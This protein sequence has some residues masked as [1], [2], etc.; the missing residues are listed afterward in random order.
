MSVQCGV[1]EEYDGPHLESK[2]KEESLVEEEFKE[3]RGDVNALRTTIG[4][5]LAEGAELEDLQ[6][7]QLCQMGFFFFE[8]ISTWLY[9]G[10]SPSSDRDD[11]DSK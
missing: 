9:R 11:D 7:R 5:N 3:E 10:E 2:N 6:D 1:K 8:M 4:T